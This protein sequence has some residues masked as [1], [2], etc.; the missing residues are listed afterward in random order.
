MVLAAIGQRSDI[1]VHELASTMAMDRTTMGKNLRLLAEDGLVS[2]NV[3]ETDRRGRN[4]ALTRKGRMLLDGAY[5]LWKHAH[6][7]LGKAHGREFLDQLRIMLKQL[8]SV[9]PS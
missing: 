8:D 6:D 7:T 9:R 2:V 1:S 4:I 3:S 5:P